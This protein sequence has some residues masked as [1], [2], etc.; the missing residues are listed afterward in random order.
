MKQYFKIIGFVILVVLAISLVLYVY[1][2]IKYFDEIPST[3][4]AFLIIQLI[5][6]LFF[7]PSI[8]YLFIYVS[9]NLDKNEINKKIKDENLYC[10]K[11]Y[12]DLLGQINDL[13]EEI[14]ILKTKLTRFEDK[15]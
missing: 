13:N 7:G 14:I 6:Y 11:Q 15:K 3:T 5:F 10:K 12:N 9:D 4:M 2:M 8:G 1:Y